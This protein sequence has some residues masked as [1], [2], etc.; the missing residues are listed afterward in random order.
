MLISCPRSQTS[1]YCYHCYNT[2]AVSAFLDRSRQ[3]KETGG[4]FWCLFEA[5]SRKVPKK[6]FF[7]ARFPKK[8]NFQNHELALGFYIYV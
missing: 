7:W 3:E 8:C 6:V 1:R 4:S 5:S 2:C